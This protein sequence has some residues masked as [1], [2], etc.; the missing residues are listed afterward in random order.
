M[1]RAEGLPANEKH[2]YLAGEYDD[3]GP[4]RS[5]YPRYERITQIPPPRASCPAG[6]ETLA[7]HEA[8]RGDSGYA[9]SMQAANTCAVG[10]SESNH[11]FV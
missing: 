8:G 10:M 9:L 3:I 1:T 5:V 2:V 6:T 11:H 4:G 7:R